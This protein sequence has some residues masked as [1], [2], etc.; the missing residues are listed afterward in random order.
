MQTGS[1]TA[2]ARPAVTAGQ[3]V[4][5]QPISVTSTGNWSN[6]PNAFTYQWLSCSSALVCTAIP[7]ATGS[8][9]TPGASQV[10]QDLQAAI[11]AS[12]AAGA[13]EST[14][15]ITTSVKSAAP[16]V[17]TAP[18]LSTRDVQQGTSL[19]TSQGTWGNSPTSFAVQWSD[20]QGSTCTAIGGATSTTYTPTATDVG[21]TLEATVTATNAI[22]S[23]SST[24]TASQAVLPP[25]GA[26]TDL[27]VAVAGSLCTQELVTGS[28]GN[29]WLGNTNSK[30]IDKITPSGTVTGYSIPTGADPCALTLGPDGNV[31]FAA[32]S[33]PTVGNVTPSGTV[34]D[35]SAGSNTSPQGITAGSDGNLYF[36][37]GGANAIVRLTTSG[38]MTSFT[39][40]LAG[41]VP[42][43]ITAGPDGA[44]WFTETDAADVGRMTTSGSFSEVSTGAMQGNGI[45]A[46]SDTNVWATD[47]ASDEI[48]RIT[49]AGVVTHFADPITGA[50]PFD[51]VPG[52]DGALW[53]GQ[54]TQPFVGRIDTSGNVTEW[55]V[56]SGGNSAYVAVGP[57]RYIWYDSTV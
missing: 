37:E 19:S 5:G 36:T 9:F 56:P 46:G 12:N 24:S 57:D 3:P 21:S 28:D 52:D 7:G 39:T 13:G 8:S 42:N 11:I 38:A 34:T 18:A 55:S 48:L 33:P 41:S 50:K 4:Q 1:P 23:T 22:G 29:L 44:L 17:Q 10:G 47:T 54:D 53:F 30:Q 49:P 2:S 35:W 15:P 6:S 26:A 32:I 27:P 51:I 40:P 20:C 25:A 14:S 31:W 43:V 45:A 16:F